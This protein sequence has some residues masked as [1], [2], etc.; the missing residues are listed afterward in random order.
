MNIFKTK[1]FDTVIGQGVKIT[2]QVS[3]TNGSVMVIDSG[4]IVAG[5]IFQKDTNVVDNTV[6]EVHGEATGPMI[7]VSNITITGTVTTNRIWVEGTLALKSG[8]ALNAAEIYYR[9]LV[10][11]PGAL[12][13]GTML[14][15]DHSSKGEQV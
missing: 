11:E 10:I 1:G 2:G 15:L 13:H 12:V 14:H 4:A 6:L 9:N 5:D 7:H 8:A 3:V